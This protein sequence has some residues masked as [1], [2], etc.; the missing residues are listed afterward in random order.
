MSLKVKKSNEAQSL[1]TQEQL[2]VL[3][4]MNRSDFSELVVAL[5]GGSSKNAK[6]QPAKLENFDGAY[7]QKVVH[8]WL[9]EMEDYLH[10]AKVGQ[11]SAVEL[12]Q[13]Y[14]KGYAA[15]WWRTVR[16]EEGKSHGYTWELFKECVEAK[17][18]PRNFD[19]I[20]RCKL[21]NLVNATNDN[22]QQYVKAYSE[23]MLEI[24]H[25]HELDRM[26]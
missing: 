12:A 20:S 1:F 3:L 10:A 5:K 14:L 19:Y 25:M 9:A 24:R 7:D 23:L 4:K 18:V 16:Q 17:F 15:T 11:H 21:H 8:A 2:E 13:S 26:C 22:L 6:F